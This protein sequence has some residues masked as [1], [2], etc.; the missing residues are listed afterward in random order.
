MDKSS[1]DISNTISRI[2]VILGSTVTLMVGGLIY[3][4]FRPAEASFLTWFGIA[5]SDNWLTLIREKSLSLTYLLPP[6]LVYSLP[7]G[8]WAYAYSLIMLSIW[9]GSSSYMRYVWFLSIP[10]L[11]FGF[12]L[13]QLAGYLQGTFCLFDLTWGA[14]GIS[15]GYL[16]VYLKNYKLKL[17]I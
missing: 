6:W 12:E 14:L 1:I 8:L 5:G 11:V 4:L 16:T 17:L 15:V 3:L 2:R 10:V 9:K 13:L 7:N